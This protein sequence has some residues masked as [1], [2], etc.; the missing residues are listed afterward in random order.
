M[1]QEISLYIKKIL[2]LF[3]DNWAASLETG[4]HSLSKNRDRALNQP[5]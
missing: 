2:I 1:L 4:T 5:G 3:R